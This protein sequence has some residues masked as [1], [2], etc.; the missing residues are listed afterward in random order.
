MG[1]R[2]LDS[3]V[4]S[5]LQN[6]WSI[7]YGALG[8]LLMTVAVASII[9]FRAPASQ[10]VY[11]LLRDVLIYMSGFLTLALLLVLLVVLGV[12]RRRRREQRRFSKY[13][14]TVKGPIDYHAELAPATSNLQKVLTEIGGE[15][16]R[17]SERI[18]EIVLVTETVVNPKVR[19]KAISKSAS[20][21]NK[22]LERIE[23]AAERLIEVTDAVLEVSV[24]LLQH[25]PSASQGNRAP[26][27][28]V[29]SALIV[30]DDA[31]DQVI[32]TQEQMRQSAKAAYGQVSM[33]VHT[34][35]NWIMATNKQVVDVMTSFR[36]RLAVD[37]VPLLNRKLST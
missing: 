8:W 2:L 29:Q 14:S 20:A 37:L 1:T 28:Q 4:D 12:W 5:A 3:A 26:L 32:K 25:A 22:R 17:L 6:I 19:Q 9:Y 15:T 31:A 34:S 10:W 33:D 27:M 30:M 35:L 21:L 13:A 24:G 11:G 23:K 16:V 36:Q 18:G 7:V